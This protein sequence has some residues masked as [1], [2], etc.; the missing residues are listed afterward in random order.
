MV[1]PPDVLTPPVELLA[2]SNRDGKELERC[3]KASEDGW[4]ALDFHRQVDASSSS[5]RMRT[6]CCLAGTIRW[7][8][9]VVM[10]TARRRVRS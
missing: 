5:A 8:G 6:G 4:F 9:T 2:G 10:T 7:A 3:Y 1:T